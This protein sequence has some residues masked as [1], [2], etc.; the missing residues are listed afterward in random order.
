[1]TDDTAND[2]EADAASPGSA[3]C[4]CGSEVG[5]GGHSAAMDPEAKRVL[6]TRLRRIEGQVRG[7]HKMIE[8]E[9]WCADVL[10]QVNSVQEALRGVSRGLLRNHLAHCA[11]DA[12][13][14][15]DPARADAVFGE[16]TDL[17]FRSVR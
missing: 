5:P 4:A 13:R 14:S 12:V 10:T 11:A 2:T 7:L 17:M 8:D 6:L 3:A 15:G 9:R 16:L 1:M